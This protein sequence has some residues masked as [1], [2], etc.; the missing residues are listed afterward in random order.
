M[1][2]ERNLVSG[3]IDKIGKKVRLEGW[4][5]SVRDHGKI[6]FIDLRD[7]SGIVQCVGTNLER[8]SPESVVEIIGTV[9]ARPEKLVN[10]KIETGNVEIQIDSLKVISPAAELPFD[11][12]T[13]DLN[14]D[15]PT[16]L[17]YRALTLRHKKQQAIFRVQ[18]V[19]IDAFR[20]AL[21]EKDFIEFQAPSIISSVPEGGAEVFK[22]KYFDHEAYLS[23]SPQLYKSLLVGVFERVFSVNQIFRAEPSVTTRH[24]TEVTSLDAE[25]GFIDSWKDVLEMEEYVIRYIFSEVEKE[26][27]NEL[28]LFGATLPKLSNKIPIL[29]LR[30]AQEIIF[31]R[32]GKDVRAE[33]DLAPEDEREICK[34][35][36]EEKGSD[37]VFI[38]HFVTKKKPFYVYA[39][40]E[41]PTYGFSVDLLGRGVE[42][43][44]GGQR[45]NN[46]KEI[47]EHIHDWGLKEKD[48]E[49]YLQSFKYGVPPLGGFALGAERVTMHILG[50]K[51]IREASLFPRDMERID[52]R[53]SK[54][55]QK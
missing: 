19:I 7:R 32:T 44:S 6:S 39:D 53:L 55:A 23:Q 14:L 52:T 20:R 48:V 47:V 43:S 36:L 26:C 8:V 41:D 24:L 13:D 5:N 15:L 3:V 10:P 35:S 21:L 28:A 50:L 42:W 45:L 25:F 54:T 37:L 22:V 33:K 2:M 12:G 46:Y 29:K 11:M 34:W 40:P 38:S 1:T 16:L 18:A 31:E 4:V 51:N 30:E 49:L 27:R 9:A 17:D